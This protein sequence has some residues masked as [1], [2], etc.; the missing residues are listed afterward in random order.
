MINIETHAKNVQEPYYL[1]PRLKQVA[2]HLIDGK[3][4]KEIAT[5]LGISINVARAYIQEVYARLDVRDQLHLILIMYLPL[6]SPLIARS[7]Y[8][9]SPK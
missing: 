6:N 7:R 5:L 3:G 4:K 9:S 8:E 2:K 1:S